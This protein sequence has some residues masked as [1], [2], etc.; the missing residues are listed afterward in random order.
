MIEG[1]IST[2]LGALVSGRCYPSHFPQEPTLPTWPAIRYTISNDADEVLCGSAGAD[3][4][5]IHVQIDAV[6]KTW[7]AMIT[8]RDQII[9]ALQGTG[10]PNARQPGGFQTFDEETKTHRSV[11]FYLFQQSTPV[12][13]P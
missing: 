3:T 5:D 9:G 12:T 2:V 4:D 10:T 1:T 13:S 7:G 6:A 11:L 8:L